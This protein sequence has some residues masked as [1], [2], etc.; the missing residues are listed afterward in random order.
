MTAGRADGGL[1]P[2]RILATVLA[3]FAAGYF[4][5]YLLRAVNAVVA[6][7]LVAAVGLSAGTWGC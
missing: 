5:S 7:D 3:P 6:P 2:A 4:C 1:S